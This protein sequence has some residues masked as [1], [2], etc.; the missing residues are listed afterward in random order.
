MTARA[1]GLRFTFGT[2][3]GTSF[4]VILALA[5]LGS[6]ISYIKLAA[7]I[8][9]VDATFEL[10]FPS[11][12]AI[13]VLQRDM[14]MTSVKARQAI[15]AG[16]Q[17]DRREVAQK[18]WEK[19]WGTVAK[20]LVTFDALAPKW[21]LQTNRDRLA[22]IKQRL[23]VLHDAQQ[24][25]IGHAVG[26]RDDVIKAGNEYTDRGTSAAEAVRQTTEA[27]SD[28][29]HVL[30][31]KNKAD[32]HAA[33]RSLKMTLGATTLAALVFGTVAAIV[34]SRRT[35]SRL[36]RLTQMIQ[37]I[38]EGEGDITRRLEASVGFGN[39]ELG[40]VSRFFNLFM[41]KLQ[42]ILRG[43][44]SHT[45]K[46]AAASQQ[47]L[48]ASEQ[49][50]SNSAETANQSTSVSQVTQQVS[51]NLQSLSTGAGEMTS[52]IQSIAANAHEAAKVA[53]S[54]VSSAETATPTVAKLGHSS[55][56]IGEVIKVITTIAQ[57]TNLLALNATIEAARAGEAGKGFAVVANEVKELA[58]QTAKA[59]EDISRKIEAIQTD[60]KGA[61]D[62]IGQI[63][64]II[65]QINDI[66]NTIAGAVEEQTAT[67]G[68]I[69]RNV[70]EA[71]KGSSEIAQ[72]ITGVAQAARST[73]QGASNTKGSADE[74]SKMAVDLQKLVSQFKF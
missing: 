35:A 53:S 21:V 3:L 27:M 60:T 12:E 20:D 36:K 70:N 45:Q 71:A 24:E 15:L 42:E 11:S 61:V 10:R 51:Q 25:A 65:N 50:T 22:E 16:S 17:P 28:S 4:G 48:A 66:Q 41:D 34:L 18:A 23:T 26:D 2:K 30:L 69:S 8:Q 44:S 43:I 13:N 67:T 32:V 31:E 19:T 39:D 47:L 29:F 64:K 14:N 74:L 46:L 72:N 73:T 62:A 9:D 5:V 58:K 37:D 40:E 49:I 38:A 68:E 33:T 54:A 52:T 56:E 1:S 59:T 55:L 7:V 6:T 57:Q 63:G